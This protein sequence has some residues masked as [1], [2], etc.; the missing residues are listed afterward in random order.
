MEMQQHVQQGL[1]LYVLG[2]IQME[3]PHHMYLRYKKLT[4]HVFHQERHFG[5]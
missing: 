4:F 2:D 1:Y 3:G 5:S